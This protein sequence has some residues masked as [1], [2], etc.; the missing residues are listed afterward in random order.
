MDYFY[1]QC[2]DCKK[3]VAKN[4]ISK[5]N[6][7]YYCYSCAMKLFFKNYNEKVVY[8]KSKK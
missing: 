8:G 7:E 4:K 3:K 1:I 6:D 2:S 5:M